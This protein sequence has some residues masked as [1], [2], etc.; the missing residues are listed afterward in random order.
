MSALADSKPEATETDQ[1]QAP[2]EQLDQ[3]MMY[4][5]QALDLQSKVEAEQRCS[6]RLLA[7]QGSNC[8]DQR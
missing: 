6:M 5:L 3:M 4:S 8:L 2:S 1:I 7:K